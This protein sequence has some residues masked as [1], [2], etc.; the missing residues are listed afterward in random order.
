[1]Q[2]KPVTNH[3]V[4]WSWLRAEISHPSHQFK[5]GYNRYVNQYGQ[6]KLDNPCFTDEEENRVRGEIFQHVRGKYSI[7]R[8]LSD[9]TK[10]Y[11]VG[12]FFW[13]A[14]RQ[15]RSPW[16]PGLDEIRVRRSLDLNGIIMWGHKMGGPYILLEGN[17][18]WYWR[19]V[20]F[21]YFAEVYVGISQSKYEICGGCGC[22]QCKE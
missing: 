17:H 6:P 3:E 10:W 15:V 14:C 18:R 16:P 7:G 2:W 22:N 19:N 4:I 20:F 12:M 21:P 5:G 11:K 8:P 13:G 1:M 9:D